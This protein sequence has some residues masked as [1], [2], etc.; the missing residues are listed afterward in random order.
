MK[1]TLQIHVTQVDLDNG[2]PCS[3]GLCPFARALNRQLA[4][5]FPD[6]KLSAR[7]GTEVIT[8]FAPTGQK[9]WE[10][11]PLQGPVAHM[12]LDGAM[13]NFIQRYDATTS[14]PTPKPK[15]Q[16]FELEVNL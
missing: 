13:K 8:I 10:G 12:P 4:L 16:C 14:P 7:I 3:S 15:A 2:V 6:R 1:T 5:Q 11:Q 9:N